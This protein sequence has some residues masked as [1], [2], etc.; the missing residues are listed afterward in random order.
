MEKQSLTS[1]K[2]SGRHET[3]KLNISVFRIEYFVTGW[4]SLNL[5]LD[6]STKKAGALFSVKKPNEKCALKVMH[7]FIF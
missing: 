4:I 5:Y 2:S 7:F 1:I 3:T 6:S